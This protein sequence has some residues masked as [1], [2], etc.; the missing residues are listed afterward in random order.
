MIKFQ[1]CTCNASR[2]IKSLSSDR[3]T[4]GF[5]KV[6]HMSLP[7]ICTGVLK[8]ILYR[9]DICRQMWAS[10]EEMDV[11]KDIQVLPH[12]FTY[13]G[14]SINLCAF[15]NLNNAE[16]D[17]CSRNQGSFKLDNQKKCIAQK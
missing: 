10:A 3:Q 4:D 8:N 1:T 12:T 5:R 7:C 14:E 9:V 15:R 11:Q 17:G 16:V 13:K 6:M 2:D